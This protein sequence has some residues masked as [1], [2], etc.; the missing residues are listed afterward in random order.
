MN[1]IGVIGINW[2]NGGADTLARFTVPDPVAGQRLQLVR[3]PVAEIERPGFEH[4]E[5][6]AAFGDVP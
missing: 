2:R 6:I 5:R 4:F 3:R 1:R